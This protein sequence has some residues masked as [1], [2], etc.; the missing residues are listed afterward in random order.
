MTRNLYEPHTCSWY[1]LNLDVTDA[2]IPGVIED[3]NISNPNISKISYSQVWDFEPQHIL[4]ESWLADLP[5]VTR[6]LVFGRSSDQIDTVAHLDHP[7]SN[8]SAEDWDYL[9][10]AINW[11]VGPDHRAM[12]WWSVNGQQGQTMDLPSVDQGQYVQW[13]LTQLQLIDQCVIGDR[14]T[15]VRIDQPHS[16]A[17]GSDTRISI[18]LRLAPRSVEWRQIVKDFEPWL[19][20]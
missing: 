3:L 20:V 12:Q 2:L 14:A 7:K 19:G 6:V 5:W 4:T 9:P 11:C 18:S 1:R 17:A 13:P 8:P 16:I 10:A 15:L